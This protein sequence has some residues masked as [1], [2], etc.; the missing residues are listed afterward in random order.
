MPEDYYQKQ[1]ARIER[2]RELA[3]KNTVKAESLFNRA[4]QMAEVIPFGQPILVGHYSEKSDRSYRNRIQNTWERAAETAKKADYYKSR[5]LSADSNRAISSDAPDAIELLKEKLA[6]C[7]EFQEHAKTVNKICRKK[8]SDEEKIKL[9]IESGLKESTAKNCITPDEFGRT[10]VPSYALTNNN[11]N[12]KR[13]K[14]RIALLEKQKNDITTE[15]TIGDIT[16][17]DSVEDNRIMITFPGMPDEG[18]RNK[19]KSYGFRWSPSNKAWQAFRTAKWKIPYIIKALTAM[20]AY[21]TP[22]TKYPQ[23]TCQNYNLYLSGHWFNTVLWGDAS[24]E[25]IE[26]L[27]F[28]GINNKPAEWLITGMI[29]S[30]PCEVP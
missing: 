7:V 2:F 23:P 29:T 10:G 15:I 4:H 3:E 20:P 16:I 28:D 24:S 13:I 14:D 5:A 9:L 17:T 18:I 30:Q 26:N 25:E 11:G 8:C 6:K 21:V 1:E 19:L 27:F 12:M 22:F